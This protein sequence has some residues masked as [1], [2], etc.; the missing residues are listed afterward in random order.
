M[1]SQSSKY[2]KCAG[3]KNIQLGFGHW[4]PVAGYKGRQVLMKSYFLSKYPGKWNEDG[5]IFT[6]L[7]PRWTVIGD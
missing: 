5:I 6:E 7:A 1:R 4:D 3:F 2:I